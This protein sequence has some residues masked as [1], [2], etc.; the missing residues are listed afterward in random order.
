MEFS[1]QTT[2]RDYDQKATEIEGAGL[3]SPSMKTDRIDR[4]FW[5]ICKW[6]SDVDMFL[7]DLSDLPIW[8]FCAEIVS[9]QLLE[10]ASK[11]FGQ[12]LYHHFEYCQYGFETVYG[13]PVSIKQNISLSPAQIQ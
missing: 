10:F 6:Y 4:F 2:K 7:N 12:K 11:T 5:Y 3:I 1:N 9:P 8:E 13:Q